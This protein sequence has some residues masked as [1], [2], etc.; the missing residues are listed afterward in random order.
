[1]A[2]HVLLNPK[3][4]IYIMGGA[5]LANIIAGILAPSQTIFY[6]LL[7]GIIGFVLSFKY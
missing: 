5:T 2:M 1:M 6:T 7:G 4:I 3:T